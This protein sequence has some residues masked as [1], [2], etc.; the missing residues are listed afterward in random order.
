MLELAAVNDKVVVAGRD[1]LA[2]SVM[3]SAD[4]L[5]ANTAWSAIIGSSSLI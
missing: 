2:I 5:V 3:G 1:S 4:V